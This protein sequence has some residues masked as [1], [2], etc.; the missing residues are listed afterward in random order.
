MK[1]VETNISPYLQQPLRTLDEVQQERERRQQ[2]LAAAGFPAAQNIVLT[3]AEP[4]AAN[5]NAAPASGPGASP[6][7]VDQ[8]V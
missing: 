2:E 7:L 1:P 3:S 4:A 8:T 6:S 5:Q